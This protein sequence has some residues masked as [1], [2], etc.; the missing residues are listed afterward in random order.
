SELE[1]LD[2]NAGALTAF[3]RQHREWDG[4]PKK[5]RGE[6]P[7]PPPR[8]TCLLDDLTLAVIA[9][10]L[11]DNPRGGL[12]VKDELAGWLGS[13]GQF[14]RTPGGAVADVSGWLS[15]FNGERLIL[16]RKTN[17]ESHRIFHPRL[18]IAGCIPP[19]VLRG[20]L[21]KDFFQ[22]GL[23]ARFFFAAPPPSANV[24]T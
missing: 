17:R 7:H 13:F 4:L 8:L 10:I 23:P 2:H 24:W 1:L 16:D 18:S 19:S 3:E 22:R 9:P 21:T 5:A 11:R 6:E 20:A 14:S 12:V 15:L